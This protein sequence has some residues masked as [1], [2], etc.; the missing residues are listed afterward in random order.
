MFF[1]KVQSLGGED[2]EDDIIFF[3]QEFV[4]EAIDILQSDMLLFIVLDNCSLIDTASWK[5]FDLIV[6]DCCNLIIIM[7]FQASDTSQ[8]LYG[9]DNKRRRGMNFKIS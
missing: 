6:S 9:E 7:A 1:V 2:N 8:Y 4:I 3:L 5:L